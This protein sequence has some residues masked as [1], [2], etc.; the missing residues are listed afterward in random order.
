MPEVA[1]VKDNLKKALLESYLTEYKELMETWRSLETKAQSSLTVNGFFIAAAFAFVGRLE[2]ETTLPEKLFLGGMI[3]LLCL[4]VWRA[5]AA[6]KTGEIPSP[7]IGGG[8]CKFATDLIN[9]SDDSEFRER[10]P[11]F[12]GDQVRKWNRTIEA[13]NKMIES[14]I[15]ILRN[16]QHCLMIAVA[17]AAILAILR[18]AKS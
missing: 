11:R 12:T 10:L 15:H 2:A 4:S 5:M 3:I 8:L 6:L 18:I 13:A 17:F 16:S 14:K 9:V 1:E 7:P